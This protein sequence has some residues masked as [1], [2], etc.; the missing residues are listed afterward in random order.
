[1]KIAFPTDEHRPFH[2]PQAVE[3]AQ[4]LTSDFNPDLLV[5][6]SDGIDFYS[7]S[8]FDKIPNYPKGGIQEEINSWKLGQREWRDAAPNAVRKFIRGNH[9]F[10]LEKFARKHPE[11][12]GYESF[13]IELALGL[14]QLGIEYDSD[15]IL[16]ENTLKIFHGEIVRKFSG[17]SAKA[18]LEKERF[19][20]STLSGHTHR[21]GL[22]ITRT[23]NGNVR[24]MEAFCLCN[25]EPEYFRSPDWQN[26]I[27]FTTAKNGHVAFE[28]VEFY[29]TGNRLSAIW[30]DK[31]YQV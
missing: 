14:D 4:K 29:T 21:G 30:R 9:E 2:N 18:E 27:V 1:M 3:L 11:V 24:S 16:I 19:A 20:I 15:E 23:R 25:L 17:M 13:Q 8:S 6:G 22:H 7:I 28:P 10:R 26:G 31:E 5:V 12:Y